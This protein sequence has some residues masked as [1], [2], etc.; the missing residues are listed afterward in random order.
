MTVY[1]QELQGSICHRLHV[2]GVPP[3]YHGQFAVLVDRWVHCSGIEWTIKRLKSLKVD[4]YR[5]RSG[6]PALTPAKKS[7]KGDFY[8][9]IGSLFR[10]ARK[11]ERTFQSVVN[12]FMCYS[13]F[14]SPK[15]TENQR[16]KFLSA[17]EADT[18]CV[19][20]EFYKE[21]ALLIDSW[22]KR[23][24]RVGEPKSIFTRRGSE[25]KKAPIL[26]HR[27][28]PQKGSG[29]AALSFFNDPASQMLYQRYEPLYSKV[30]EGSSLNYLLSNVDPYQCLPDDITIT[31]GEVHFLQ[32][33]GY[34][35]RAI[36]SPYLVHQQAL[37]PL[38]ETLYDHMRTLPWDCTFD[39]A[40]PVPHIQEH[41]TSGRYIHSVD[42][43]NATDYFPLEVQLTALRAL[44]G[45]H[46][47]IDLFAEISRSRWQS[48]IGTI[49]WKQGQPLG[50]F[51][52]FA[53]FGLTHGYLLLFL[54]GKRYENEF[55]VLGD[56]VVILDDHLYFKYISYLGLLGCPY[57][58]EKSLSSSR[59][60]EF[61]G[62]VITKDS[63][64][65]S[66]KWREVSNDN[67]IDLLRNYGRRA[68]S[69]LSSNQKQVVRRIQHLVGPIGLNWSYK[70]STLELM[71]QATRAIY[72][73]MD[74]D[75]QSLTELRSTLNS[76][77]YS[78]PHSV[79]NDEF[80]IDSDMGIDVGTM[81]DS[82]DIES[83]NGLSQTFDEK[84]SET[85]QH[86]FPNEWVANIRDA[87]LLGGYAGMPRAV[88]LTDL[89]LA[90]VEST[91]VTQLE[92]YRKLLHM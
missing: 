85:F 23:K 87:N 7:R 61:G 71:T 6:L 65:Q 33:P 39:H 14:K 59:L 47:S 64:I 86:I 13:L 63:V 73:Q 79:M 1:S 51:P 78:T 49:Q 19:P 52:S 67:F 83:L 70:G 25:S 36:A 21:F 55:F 9:V 44:I 29:L 41:L 72:K 77:V 76:N 18:N 74:R 11:S 30:V 88:G 16:E 22:N 92:W 75:E 80:R 5:D 17:V 24:L 84:V 32:E 57:S 12:T 4:L 10:Y 43:S 81:I 62:K 35:L 20:R 37:Q 90:T 40:K 50:L 53:S 89:P 91:R 45:D 66:Y 28:M 15:L 54:L 58:P 3:V 42:L 82:I 48:T 27:S 69:L 31:G 38:G 34:K 8:G 68:V 2:F 26:G 60:A 56:D 46:L